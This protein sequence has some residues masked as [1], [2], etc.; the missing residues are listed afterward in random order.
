[1]PTSNLSSDSP[2]KHKSDDRLGFEPHAI[3][4]AKAIADYVRPVD[5]TDPRPGMVA[6][7]EGAW[8]TGKSTYLN[9]L[10]E[11]LAPFAVNNELVIVDFD[12]WWLSEKD[13]LIL[14]FFQLLVSTLPVGKQP[15]VAKAVAQLAGASKSIPDWAVDL[16]DNDEK[17][18]TFGRVLRAL[19]ESGGALDTWLSRGVSP[20]K[21]RDRVASTIAK[22][23]IGLV[24]FVDDLDR[25]EGREALDV[26][27]F[28]K[29]I[30]DLPG[31]F[32]VLAFAPTELGISLREAG[33]ED[34]NMFLEKIVQ[35]SVQLPTPAHWRMR[36]IVIDAMS[37]ILGIKPEV[38]AVDQR[39]ETV[40]VELLSK[41][42]DLA[43]LSNNVAIVLNKVLGE[44]D[45]IDFACLQ[46]IRLMDPDL[47]AAIRTNQG[48]LTDAFPRRN[49]IEDVIANLDT[50]KSAREQLRRDALHLS[51]P[52]ER[53][54]ERMLKALFPKCVLWAETSEKKDETELLRRRSV[55]L[56][57]FFETYFR[58]E[59]LPEVMS[60]A[61]FKRLL[62]LRSKDELAAA[63]KAVAESEHGRAL[64]SNVI[65]MLGAEEIEKSE[66]V[67]LA[68]LSLDRSF[69]FPDRGADWSVRLEIAQLI[70]RSYR[71]TTNSE[72]RK[73]VITA[74]GNNGAI[75]TCGALAFML[76]RANREMGS[77][78]VDA[79]VRDLYAN[80]MSKDD[81]ALF[82]AQFSRVMMDTANQGEMLSVPNV[83]FLLTVWCIWDKLAAST[84]G[85]INVEPKK[86]LA[87]FL[88]AFAG[89]VIPSE[90][91]LAFFST[92]EQFNQRLDALIA[93]S[94]DD[95]AAALARRA[96]FQG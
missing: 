11:E 57:Q 9:F 19:R 36:A 31:V 75:L 28:V 77:E 48:V 22:A 82:K 86:G 8:G 25:L 91:I 43:R 18:S 13:S 21:A 72:F 15:D 53:R 33:I 60:V 10:K 63:I 88:R 26:L 41:P 62:S 87:Q 6:S 90:V 46:A 29:S 61:D 34:P 17:P 69:Y 42:R 81:Y 79:Y 47:F 74:A 30:G 73:A 95:T 2:K 70:A 80:L 14:S 66:N 58:L 37:D 24:V 27:R 85:R 3:Q 45:P 40:V 68:F 65:E 20:R 50:D 89:Y 5:D 16:L 32:Y 94:D 84:W 78:P 23:K 96:R 35:T 64:V 55:A 12:P 59:I 52:N 49:L 4:L 44:V 92:T 93:Q 83:P 7:I 54:R 67:S 38:L 51:G 56:G 71:A 39:F 76:A 1:M